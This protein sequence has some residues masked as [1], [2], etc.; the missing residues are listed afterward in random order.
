[1]TIKVTMNLTEHDVR[2]AD[3]LVGL[4]GSRNKARRR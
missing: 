2:N 1:M 3:T 4:I